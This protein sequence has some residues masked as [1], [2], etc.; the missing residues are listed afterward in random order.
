MAYVTA[1]FLETWQTG[2]AVGAD[3]PR[4]V[5]QVRRGNWRR[6]YREWTGEL[7]ALIPGE[8]VD[9]NNDG[10]PVDNGY[11]YPIFTETTEWEDLPNVGSVE[12]TND[13][14][15]R[16]LAV[17]TIV[18]DNVEYVAQTGPGGDY[19]SI[20]RGYFAP[21]RGDD[22]GDWRPS[23]GVAANDWT[24]KVD[25]MADVRIWQGFGEPE[26]VD[27]EMPSD[28]G[29]NGT[30]VFRGLIDDVDLTAQPVHISIVARAGK[31]L[32]DSRVFGW[33]KSRQLKDPITFMDEEEF[34]EEQAES[35][36]SGVVLKA[37]GQTIRVLDVSDMVRVVLRWAGFD[38]WEIEDAGVSL[39]GRFVV[40]RSNYLIDIITAACEQTGF[41]FFLAD[42]LDGDSQGVP[43][44]RR[45]AAVIRE[46]AAIAAEVRDTDLI[47]DHRAKLTEAPRGY[48]IR[49]RG[50]ASRVYGDPLGGDSV[51]TSP[52]IRHTVGCRAGCYLIAIAEAL[53]ATTSVVE[54]PGNPIIELDDQVGI[55][56][57]ATG[58]NSRLWVSARTSSFTTGE[59]AS[60]TV[61][62]TGALID[63]PYLVAIIDEI[64]D[65]DWPGTAPPAVRSGTREPRIRA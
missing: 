62:L 15:Q 41:V 17:A 39:N 2:R 22:P 64:L 50:K 55:L 56:D 26:L 3:S 63:S 38:A 10:D 33:N 1:G 47:T 12:I 21:Y 60:W 13:F 4:C 36:A 5:V 45:D 48:I 37:G 35:A 42:P 61:T 58:I 54:L 20:Q 57:T 14:S 23:P 34:L 30:W 28:G 59:H 43:T 49:V 24:G 16:G 7:I 29:S 6:D 32:T 8:P 40:N 31:I 19:H 11:W 52:R 65:L 25:E 44:F 9:E 27:G 51:H 18:M 53:E 46:P